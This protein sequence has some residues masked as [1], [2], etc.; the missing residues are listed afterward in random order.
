MSP[1]LGQLRLAHL[2]LSTERRPYR[3][4]INPLLRRAF[5]LSVVLTFVYFLFM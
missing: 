1:T 2:L 3:R 5:D 4:R